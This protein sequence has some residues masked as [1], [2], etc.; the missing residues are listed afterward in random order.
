MEN[1]SWKFATFVLGGVIVGY[2]IA[3]AN[4]SAL[5]GDIAAL[6]ENTKVIEVEVG[7]TVEETVPE[8]V[9]V[10]ADDDSVLGNVNAP[11]EII[12]FS[13]YQCSYC[14][15]FHVSTFPDLKENYIDTGKVKFIYRDYPLTFHA[16]AMPA[17]AAAECAGDQ[18]MYYEMQDVIFVN[19]NEWSSSP[20]ADQLFATYATELGLDI[21][22]F[23]SCYASEEVQEEIKGDMRDGIT[24][25]VRAT[26]TFFINGQKLEGAQPYSVFESVL[27]SML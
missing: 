20:E 8:M 6:E 9:E 25:G 19:L 27:E 7:D 2:F 3:Q 22:E 13:D 5:M 1:N 12:E 17:A 4:P 11:I 24:A 16:N 26:P 21:A 18:D 15:R 23:E 10:T 14:Q